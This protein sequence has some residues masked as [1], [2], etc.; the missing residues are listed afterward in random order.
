MKAWGTFS[1]LTLR[2]C[3]SFVGEA[4]VWTLRL[5]RL[6]LWPSGRPSR[7]G[8]KTTKEQCCSR[9]RLASRSNVSTGLA[10]V[11]RVSGWELLRGSDFSRLHRGFGAGGRLW[12]C[13]FAG[14]GEASAVKNTSGC[15]LYSKLTMTRSGPAAKVDFIKVGFVSSGLNLSQP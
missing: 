14:W 10:N 7:L 6:V 5:A 15:E 1:N 2:R 12:L 11:A 13:V 3:K 4:D 8:Y 9:A